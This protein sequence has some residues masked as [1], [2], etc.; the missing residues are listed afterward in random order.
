MRLE[1]V[2]HGTAPFYAR[3][4]VTVRDVNKAVSMPAGYSLTFSVSAITP[5]VPARNPN[6]PPASVTS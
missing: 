1:T 6:V 3:P 4:M 2:T 5:P